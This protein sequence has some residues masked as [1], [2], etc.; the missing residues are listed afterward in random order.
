MLASLSWRQLL[1]WM[2]FAD[3]EPFDEVR[4]DL[5]SAQVV[6]TLMNAH[7]NTKKRRHPYQLK[8]ALL[9]F[10][11]S[12]PVKQTWQEKKAIMKMWYGFFEA[13]RRAEEKEAAKK[14]KRA[15]P[16]PAGVQAR[17]VRR[18]PHGRPR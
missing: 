6:L 5:R 13:Q 18:R 14:A 8:D 10:G 3:L 17:V 15:Q 2:A 4:A 9:R 16:A 12:Q 11:D 1:E 7:R